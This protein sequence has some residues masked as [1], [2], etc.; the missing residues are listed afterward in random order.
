M[1]SKATTVVAEAQTFLQMIPPTYLLAKER[2]PF[3]PAR[4]TQMDVT[5]I[6][7]SPMGRA[8]FVL[9]YVG[10]L[11]SR[12][13]V[14]AALLAQ[15][16][17]R[18]TLIF[19]TLDHPEAAGKSPSPRPHAYSLLFDTDTGCRLELHLGHQGVRGLAML[20]SGIPTPRLSQ[21]ERRA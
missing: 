5:W 19:R 17:E 18:P 1:L 10:Q 21:R 16:G 12:M 11:Y 14:D 9:T 4:S 7:L 6:E 3:L 2:Y 20:L 8:V 13:G 15:I